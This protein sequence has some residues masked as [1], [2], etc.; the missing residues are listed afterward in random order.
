MPFIKGQKNPNAGRPPGSPNKLTA[1]IKG[2]ILGE[3]NLKDFRAWRKTN[4]DGFFALVGKILPKEIEAQG[5]LQLIIR[6]CVKDD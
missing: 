1:E 6:D 5:L 4:P 3:F 2:I